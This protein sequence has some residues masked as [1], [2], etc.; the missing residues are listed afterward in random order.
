M[1]SSAYGIVA[2]IIVVNVVQ[3]YIPRNW[4]QAEL[5]DLGAWFELLF[6]NKTQA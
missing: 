6:S 2:T 4:L 5:G 3:T 1:S